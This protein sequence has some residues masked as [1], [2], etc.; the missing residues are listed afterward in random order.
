MLVQ[1]HEDESKRKQEDFRAIVKKQANE[2]AQKLYKATVSVNDEM[3]NNIEVLE[4][5]ERQLISDL[6]KTKLALLDQQKQLKGT[7]YL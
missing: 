6:T 7:L 4:D 1:Y 5:Y 2:N 3:K